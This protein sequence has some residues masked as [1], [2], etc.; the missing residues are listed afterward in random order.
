M[1]LGG[2]SKTN[3]DPP[4][5]SRI[6]LVDCSQSDHRPAAHT[7]LIHLISAAIRVQNARSSL[8]F[9]EACQTSTV[10]FARGLPVSADVTW[11]CI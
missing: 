2:D 1:G 5:R 9:V 4:R 3:T 8:P 7:D 10:A 11:P 6:C